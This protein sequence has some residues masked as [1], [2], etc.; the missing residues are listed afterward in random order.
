[1]DNLKDIFKYH[2]L[3][4]FFRKVVEEDGEREFLGSREKQGVG[5][6]GKPSIPFWLTN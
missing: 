1:M 2:L 5:E 3:L 6:D 4:I